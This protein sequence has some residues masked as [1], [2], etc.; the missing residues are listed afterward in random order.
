M[1][2]KWNYWFDLIWAL[3]IEL[4]IIKKRGEICLHL[5]FHQTSNNISKFC[6]EILLDWNIFCFVYLFKV[7]VFFFAIG[8]F[9]FE[10]IKLFLIVSYIYINKI[11]CIYICIYVK[12]VFHL[13]KRTTVI[14]MN[15]RFEVEY[16]KSG[17]CRIVCCLKFELQQIG[18]I[19]FVCMS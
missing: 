19:R 14:G 5:I 11:F 2:C 12:A 16:E 7:F 15:T 1:S 4:S 6:L 10:K 9:I 8:I 18:Q 3:M 17:N 13:T